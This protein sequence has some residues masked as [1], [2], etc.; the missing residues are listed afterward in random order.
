[1]TPSSPSAEKTKQE[2]SGPDSSGGLMDRWS[3]LTPW[4]AVLLP[5]AFVGALLSLIAVPPIRDIPALAP[6]FLGAASLLGAWALWLAVSAARQDRTLSVEVGVYKH[7]WVQA[8]TQLVILLYW[9]WHVGFVYPWIPMIVAQLFF[10]Y[11]VDSLLQWSRRDH[12]KLTFGP[13][14]IILSINLFLW[15]RPEWFHW[16]F[17]MILV[18]YLAKEFIRW[19]RGGR[20]RHIF[21]P[22][23]FP[24]SVFSVGLILTGATDVTLAS[25]IAQ[26]QYN[27]PNMYLVIFLASIPVQILFGVARVT[28]AAVITVFAVSFGYFAV[29]GTYLFFDAW[30]TVPVFLGMH[31]IITDPST[32][33]RSEAGQFIF[34]VMYALGVVGVYAVLAAIGAPRFYD[35]L[36][37]VVLLNLTV[38]QVESFVASDPF[39]LPDFSK[40]ERWLTRRQRFLGYTG[41]WAVI[42]AGLFFT[43]G[44][45]DEHPGQFLPFWQ[46]ACREGSD[47]ACSYASFMLENYCDKGS[48]WA[49]NEFGVRMTAVGNGRVAE[50]AFERGC[51]LDFQPACAN[52]S[53]AGGGMASSLARARPRVEDLPV[54]LRGSEGPIEE[55]DPE[56]LYALGCE[57]GWTS[58]CRRV[59]E[60]GGG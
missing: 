39:V 60:R 16:Q 4:K 12:Y 37:P 58:M 54:I 10:A 40:L 50:S 19:E 59:S 25:A 28:M 33:P 15:F 47:R 22:S 52:R 49:C 27:P 7:H 57:R 38:R 41:V 21:N 32:S 46:E 26:T 34:G 5:L 30:V 23:S 24:L 8:L 14:P 53:D 1:M 29:T 35:K 36:I 6:R 44:V 43:G 18:G 2:R 42:F 48:G 45:D 20:S 56:A 17:V 13:M 31:L 11:G 55:R 51:R 9:G 3:R